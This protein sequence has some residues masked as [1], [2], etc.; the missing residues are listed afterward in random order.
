MSTETNYYSIL[1]K[2][3]FKERTMNTKV[4]E[5]IEKPYLKT[6]LEDFSV[7]DTVN[8]AIKVIDTKE[9]ERIQNFEGVLIRTSGSGTRKTLTVRKI[10]A[11]GVGVERIMPLNSPVLSGVKLVKKGKARRSRLYYLRDRTG[12]SALKVGSAK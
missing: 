10:G 11:N 5:K 3:V 1:A 9:G 4:I 6:D 12:K 8:L 7:G 2:A